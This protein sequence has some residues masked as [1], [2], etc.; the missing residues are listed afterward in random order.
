MDVLATQQFLAASTPTSVGWIA[1]IIIGGVAGWLAGKVVKGEG[2]GIIFDVVV[3]VV[4]GFI[5]GFVLERG[6][7]RDV[8]A[9]GWWFTLFTAFIGAVIL[10]F[11][12]RLVRKAIS[13]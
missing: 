10:L 12:V 5:G 6:L 9:G 4:G 8:A 13:K 2:S 3:G 11:I 7:H 1:Y